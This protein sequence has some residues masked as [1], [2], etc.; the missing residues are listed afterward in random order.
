[1]KSVLKRKVSWCIA[2]LKKVFSGRMSVCIVSRDRVTID[3]EAARQSV[4]HKLEEPMP[5]WVVRDI[6]LPGG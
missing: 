1:M 3:G 4:C 5:V 6:A 2:L